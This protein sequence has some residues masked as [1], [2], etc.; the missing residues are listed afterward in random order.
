MDTGP[1]TGRKDQLQVNVWAFL[2]EI[3]R[4]ITDVRSKLWLRTA[5]ISHTHQAFK[6][7]TPEQIN[8]IVHGWLC[9][10]D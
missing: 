4:D 5:M 1:G 2:D 6:S 3:T 8:N 10:V 7:A 9:R